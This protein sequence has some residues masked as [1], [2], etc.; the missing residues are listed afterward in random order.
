MKI[1][2][3][4][5]MAKNEKGEIRKFGEFTVGLTDDLIPICQIKITKE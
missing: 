4:C 5:L 2:T 1:C 3:Y